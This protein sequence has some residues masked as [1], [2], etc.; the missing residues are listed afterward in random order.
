MKS[1][2]GKVFVWTLGLFTSLANGGYV[3]A[4]VCLFDCRLQTALPNR[5]QTDCDDILWWGPGWYNEE[6]IKCWWR[7]IL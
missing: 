7:Q 2:L 6:L 4:S 1:L 3:F 5:L